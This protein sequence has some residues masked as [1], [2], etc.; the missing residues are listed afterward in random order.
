[1][2]IENR[3]DNMKSVIKISGVILMLMITL[4]FYF[5]VFVSMQNEDNAVV[6]YFDYLGEGLIEYIMYIAILPVILYSFV[7][8]LKYYKKSNDIRKKK[9][10]INE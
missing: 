5:F 6:V 4:N 10:N 9:E 3:C 2:D 1:M 8:N 7:L